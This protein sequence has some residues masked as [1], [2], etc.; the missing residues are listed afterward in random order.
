ML[1]LKYLYENYHLAKFA[2]ENWRHDGDTLDRHLQQFR[3]SS[4]AVYPFSWQGSL[5]FLR[6]SPAEEKLESN[7]RGELEFLCYLRNNGYSAAIPVPSNSGELTIMLDSPWGRYYASVFLGAAGVPIGQTSC[8]DEILLAYGQALG[9]L[10]DLSARYSPKNRKWT[11]YNVLSWIETVLEEYHAPGKMQ[12]ELGEIRQSLS[13]LH[14]TKDT[15]GLVHY[16]F[17]PDNVFWDESSRKCTAIDFED[18]MY[19]FF[20]TDVVQALDALMEYIPADMQT[21]AED[22]FLRGYQ[23]VRPMGPGHAREWKLMRRFCDL[24]A[25]ARLIRCVA[26]RYPNEPDWMGD[27]RAKLDQKIDLLESRTAG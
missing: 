6:L 25:Y 12:A 26:E 4:N 18:G 8:K 2:L 22:T 10:H 27:L 20:L 13:R 11:C 9:Q 1:K 21:A 15:F 3:I 5:R 24:Y 19:H 16:D 17:E 14:Q 23:S 7:L